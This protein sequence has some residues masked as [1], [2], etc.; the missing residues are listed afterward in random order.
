M[1]MEI[2]DHWCTQIKFI[3]VFLLVFFFSLKWKKIMLSFYTIFVSTNKF[4]CMLQ[5][6]KFR[7][8]DITSSLSFYEIF[9]LWNQWIICLYVYIECC[10]YVMYVH[11]TIND[12][13]REIIKYIYLLLKNTH[14]SV[15][16]NETTSTTFCFVLKMHRPISTF[17]LIIAW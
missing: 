12:I 2:G 10:V 7:F 5:I 6:Y 13:R 9:Y 3:C 1:A 11:T 15:Q 14:G 17:C 8:L 16:H 4:Q